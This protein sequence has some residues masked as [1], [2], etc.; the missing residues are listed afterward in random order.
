MPDLFKQFIDKWTSPSIIILILTSVT[1]CTIWLVKLDNRVFNQNEDIS[2]NKKQI[3]ENKWHIFEHD[4][5]AETW[6]RRILLNEEHNKGRG[7]WVARN[8]AVEDYCVVAILFSGNRD[9]DWVYIMKL[10]KIKEGPYKGQYEGNHGIIYNEQEARKLNPELFER[11]K[12]K[13][14]KPKSKRTK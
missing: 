7:E 14:S 5:E 10:E 9:Y 6:K 4:K 8:R 13:A 3:E 11:P 12:A 2:V 1:Y